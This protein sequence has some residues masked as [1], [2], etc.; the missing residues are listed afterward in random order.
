LYPA[1]TRKA[2]FSSALQT[3]AILVYMLS[4]TLMST[5]SS[6]M[7]PINGVSPSSQ[8]TFGTLTKACSGEFLT[9]TCLCSLINQAL[10]F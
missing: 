6:S 8:S 4:D 3:S 10:R 5:F 7:A 2:G 9:H 1:K